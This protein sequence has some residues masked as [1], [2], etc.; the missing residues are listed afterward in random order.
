MARLLKGRQTVN[1]KTVSGFEHGAGPPAV[2]S[3]TWQ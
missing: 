3:F 2:I 1:V